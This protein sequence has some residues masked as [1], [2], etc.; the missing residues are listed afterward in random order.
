M[1]HRIEIIY[2]PELKDT[3]ALVWQK[4]LQQDFPEIEE[5]FLS[6]IYVINKDFSIDELN[7]IA[8][9]LTNPVIQHYEINKS[10]TSADNQVEVGYLPGVTDN[11][12][13]TAKEIIE[14]MFKIK[15]SA[16]QDVYSSQVFYIKGKVQDLEKMSLA[17]YNP[18]IQRTQINKGDEVVIPKVVLEQEIKVDEVDLDISEDELVELGKKGIKNKNGSCRGPLALDL[19]SLK[20]IKKYFDEQGRKPTDVELEA[21]AQTWSEHC[22]HTIFAA[23]MDEIKDGLYKHYIKRATREI[24]KDFC[25]SVFSDNSGGILFD[26]NW[27]ITDKVETHNSPSA[28]DPYGGAITGIVGVNRDTIGFGKAAMPLINKYG[29]CFADPNDKEPIYRDKDLSDKMLSPRRILDG[30]VAGVHDGGNCSGIPTPQG[31]MYFNDRYKGKPLIFVG[32]IGLIPKEINGQP[33]WEKCAKSKDKIVM[34]GGKVGADGIHGATFSSESLDSG[35]PATAVQIGDPYTQKKLSDAICKEAR[36]LGLYNSI[37][38]NGAGG[39]SSSVGEMAEQSGGC[40]VYLDKVPLKYP[41]LTPWQIWISESQERMTLA[42]PE[43]KLDEF[44][45]LMQRRGVDAWVI[46]EFNDSSKCVVKFKE[47]TVLDLDLE[48]M[49]N[50]NPKYKLKTNW[51]KPKPKQLKISQSKNQ[52]QVLLEMLSGLNNASFSFISNRYDFEVLGGSCVKPLQGE[53]QVN[54][55]ASV[56]RP[57]LESKKG[58]VSSQALYPLY[59]ELDPYNMATCSID[60]AIR[61]C[62]AVGGNVDYM[63]LL[64]N[65]CWCSSDQEDRLGQLKQA[66]K[67][68]YDTAVAFGTPF[69]SG[70]DSMFND[71]KGFDKDGQEI[72]ISVPPTLLI[73][74]TGVIEDTDKCITLDAKQEGDLV[75][76]LGETKDEMGGSEYVY[77]YLKQEGGKVPEVDTKTAIKLYK[78]LEGAIDKKLIASS[79]SIGIGGLAMGLAKTA[80]GGKLGME[81]DLS[82]LNLDNNIALYSETQSRLV[83]TVN[84][85]N[86]DKFEKIFASQK[87]YNIGE[88]IKDKFIIKDIINLDITDMEENYKKTFKDY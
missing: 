32:T 21:L 44:M 66:A 38:D 62:V 15:F 1:A 25:V 87:I 43:T 75:Y 19:E 70:K 60:T 18:L 48:F 35:S 84:P 29:Y 55:T 85:K 54:G 31:F 7:K 42:V 59:S 10:I 65:F 6:D 14:D 50:A 47:Q 58:V 9:S 3:R 71:F 34:I 40:E 80:I 41:G 79:Y 86:K 24:D 26:D 49:H 76:I 53:G 16:D 4:K 46:G 13:A 22:K 11:T 45:E 12:G 23:E 69:I 74:S 81:V 20:I 39:L 51:T 78:S 52:S 83:V 28:L 63:S 2:K 56:T 37:T 72:K 82:E 68:C 5:V 77:N 64:D 8:D 30:V 33:S 36:D 57:V 17:L 67:A 73:S 27:V 88:I 61:N